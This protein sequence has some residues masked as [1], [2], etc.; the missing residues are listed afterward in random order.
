MAEPGDFFADPN[1]KLL[2]TAVWE[3]AGK[4][5][6][7]PAWKKMHVVHAAYGFFLPYLT[8]R[9]LLARDWITNAREQLDWQ[10]GRDDG[11][12]RFLDEFFQERFR[13]TPGFTAG[14]IAN[15]EHFY[16]SALYSDMTGPALV[17]LPVAMTAVWE[18]GVGPIRIHL[19]ETAR[20][21]KGQPY[22]SKVVI[23]NIRNNARQFKGPDRNGFLFGL[24]SGAQSEL[25]RDLDKVVTDALA[26]PAEDPLKTSPMK[27]TVTHR[28]KVA[29]GECLSLIA[30]AV[31]KDPGKW[32]LIWL[33]NR[34]LIGSNYNVLKPGTWLDI[35]MLFAVTGPELA[36]C[37]RINAAWRPGTVW[38]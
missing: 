1:E 36:E 3:I 11:G 6:N 23:E 4:P 13:A 26:A 10:T 19:Q 32:P 33:R 31:Y 24:S 5:A 2:A 8:R 28:R 22:R 35:P 34:A 14:Q 30:K 37:R 38:R 15:V 7:D 21:E 16:V 27:V 17:A 20:E 18:F 25:G 29:R 12:V 9:V